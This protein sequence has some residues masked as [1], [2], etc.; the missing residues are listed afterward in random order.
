MIVQYHPL[1]ASDL[2]S[3]F[4]CYNQQ[5]A[6]LGEEFRS[7][8]YAAIERIRSNPFHFAIV[9]H[10]IR[11]CFV[12]RFPYG[13]L[14]RIVNHETLRVLVIRHHRRRPGFGLRRQ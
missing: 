9:E 8:V 12:R 10:D 3:A 7:E 2:D 5:R 6:G 1:T 11:R 13:I 4:S 14:F